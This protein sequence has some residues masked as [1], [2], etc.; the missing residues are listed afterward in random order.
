MQAKCYGGGSMHEEF[1]TLFDFH[2]LPRAIVL[3]KSLAEHCAAFRLRC[4]CMDVHAERSL[5]RMELPGLE[6]I[7]LS[8]LEEHDGELLAV[9]RERS[10]A[11]YCWTAASALCTYALKRD[12]ALEMIT[13]LD[14]DL[15]FFAS[16]SPL[17][18]EL[19][20]GSVLL[21]PHRCSLEFTAAL[22]P[23]GVPDEPGGLYNVQFTT[24]RRDR[25]GSAALAWWRS[26]C[27]EWCRDRFERGRYA[28]QK[29]LDEMPG[30]FP[31]VRTLDHLGAGLAPW[32]VSQYRLEQP[33][34]QILVNG[35]P[36]IFSHFQ[37]LKMHRGTRAARALARMT[38]AYR[39]TSGPIPL[40]WTTGWR[41]TER[42]LSLL[43]DPYMD[44]VSEACGDVVATLETDD[45]SGAPLRPAQVA[46]QLIRRRVPIAV[47]NTFWDAR[48]AVWRRRGGL[49]D[50]SRQLA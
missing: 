18:D 9:K 42:E 10:H 38:H 39:F 47:R 30:M 37:S 48:A 17:F 14:A 26:R 36:L 4:L 23:D 2:Y 49:S 5:R 22:G 45:V 25:E 3:Y 7:P 44:R 31:G 8:E 19:G 13:Y 27:I 6:V 50:A 1:C 41:L 32:N 16:P 46:F 29:Y 43:W 20:D 34:D 33:G 15:E 40:I 28:G 21:S 11:E 12:P 35:V 24:F